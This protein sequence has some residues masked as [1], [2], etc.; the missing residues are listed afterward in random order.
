MVWATLP[1]SV[2]MPTEKLIQ[3]SE[4]FMWRLSDRE[5]LNAKAMVRKP[6]CVIRFSEVFLVDIFIIFLKYYK[7]GQDNLQHLV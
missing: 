4:H 2:Q 6:K 3:P 5:W 7:P 1:V